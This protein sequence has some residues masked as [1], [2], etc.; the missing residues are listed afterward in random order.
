MKKK[1]ILKY[2]NKKNK[3]NINGYD[4]KEFFGSL[5]III[6]YLNEKN[7]EKK[8]EKFIDFLKKAPGYLK[9]SNDCKEFFLNEGNNLTIDKIMNI[10]FFIEHL[11]FK[12]LVNNLQQEYKEKIP[13]NIKEKI[14]SQLLNKENYLEGYYTIED[15][16]AAI[17]RFISRYIVGKT[18]EI[19]I[20][21][22]RELAF[23]L[24]RIDL[25]EPK[26]ANIQ[27]FEDIITNQ[28]KDIKL[29]VAQ[30][31]ELYILIGKED[32]KS[33]NNKENE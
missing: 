1:K 26:I 18:Q 29:T 32:M 23:E 33:I 17:R 7:I 30:A 20:K 25:W 11:C 31:Y 10:F 3:E 8:D 13:Q 9:I 6:F 4:F 27:N 21:L 19:D 2:I 12:D 15:L 16:G 22:D 5:Q 14:E 28:F 24:S